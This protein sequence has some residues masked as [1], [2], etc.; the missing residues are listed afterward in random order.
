MEETRAPS[1]QTDDAMIELLAAFGR[2]YFRADRAA[3]LA[4]TT[5]D[6][7][8]H[9]HAGPEAPNGRVLRGVEAVCQEVERRK[10]AWKVRYGDFETFPSKHLIT[11][12]FTVKGTDD[13]G[14]EV[15]VRAVD[16]YLVRAGRVA[17]KDSFW[18]QIE[19]DSAG[20]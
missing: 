17:R 3:L 5:D 16:L 10:A 15:D 7:E 1:D 2:A 6:F 20:R 4:C 9:Q 13:Q 19:P 18:K 8:W 14:R 11:S 12:T